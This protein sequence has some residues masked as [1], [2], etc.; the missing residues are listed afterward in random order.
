VNDSLWR[1]R[2][3][4]LGREAMRLAL[5][6]QSRWAKPLVATVPTVPPPDFTIPVFPPPDVTQD[7]PAI[8]TGGSPPTGLP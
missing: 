1:I 7:S 5:E 2:A 8:G 4:W 3:T 6:G